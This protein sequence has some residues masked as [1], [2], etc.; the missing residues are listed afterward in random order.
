VF[1]IVG[2]CGIRSGVGHIV[3]NPS[4]QGVRRLSGQARG[5]VTTIIAG[6]V[7]LRRPGP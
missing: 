1:L 3:Q 5:S 7:F 2:F 4:V 6:N